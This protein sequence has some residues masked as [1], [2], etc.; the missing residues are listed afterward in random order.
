MPIY[1]TYRV[2]ADYET[3]KVGEIERS[4]E[5]TED[6]VQHHLDVLNN[7]D[8]MQGFN[9]VETTAI[10]LLAHD[11]C[12]QFEALQVADGTP[13]LIIDIEDGGQSNYQYELVAYVTLMY[14]NDEY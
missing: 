1:C 12:I 5:T 10:E 2:K 8:F 14:E 11:E 3:V 4:F 6:W 13:E 9:Q 7:P